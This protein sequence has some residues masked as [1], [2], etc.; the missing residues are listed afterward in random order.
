V[1]LMPRGARI[2]CEQPHDRAPPV[3]SS[4]NSAPASRINEPFHAPSNNRRLA[5]SSTSDDP[6]TLIKCTETRHRDEVA[7]KSSKDEDYD[8]KA[9]EVESLGD[10]IDDLFAAQ[11]AEIRNNDKKRKDTNYWKVTV[12]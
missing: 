10:H 2:S 7:D 8:L 9:D 12:I 6:Q 3:S 5:P 4:A 11:E 1:G